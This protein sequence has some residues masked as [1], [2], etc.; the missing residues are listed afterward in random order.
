MKFAIG[1]RV[2]ITGWPEIV[3]GTVKDFTSDFGSDEHVVVEIDQNPGGGLV[4]HPSRLAKTLAPY[5]QGDPAV[6]FRWLLLDEQTRKA[7]REWD[8]AE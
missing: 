8:W 3:P 4:C 6:Y 2:E 5:V 7:W 1:D